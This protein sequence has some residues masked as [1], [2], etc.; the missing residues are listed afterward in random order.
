[1]GRRSR[2]VLNIKL[3]LVFSLKETPVKDKGN[4]AE[5][6]RKSLQDGVQA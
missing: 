6:D 5:V 3:F 2:A 1:M 4:R